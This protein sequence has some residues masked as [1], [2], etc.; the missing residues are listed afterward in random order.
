M[1]FSTGI[2]YQISLVIYV[3]VWISWIGRLYEIYYLKAAE[4]IDNCF[5]EE[6]V[7]YFRKLARMG[8]E[9][10]YRKILWKRDNQARYS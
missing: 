1:T 4:L 5:Y 10:A 7:E 6:G 8:G 3:G 9:E 2:F